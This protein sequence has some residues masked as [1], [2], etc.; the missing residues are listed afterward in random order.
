M[1]TNRAHKRAARAIA[2]SKNIRYPEAIAIA[3][4]DDRVET[5]DASVPVQELD[6]LDLQKFRIVFARR[7]ADFLAAGV[8][9]LT[10]FDMLIEGFESMP[11]QAAA[12]IVDLLPT[13]KREIANGARG[14]EA[15]RAHRD[16][17]GT[18]LVQMLAL[19]AEAGGSPARLRDAADTIEAEM[20]LG[21]S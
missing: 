16:L 6:I 4:D 1:T 10:A 12:R 19:S 3:L 13:A 14:Y 2:A 15:W 21:I 20:R 8:G 11:G 5:S 9:S 18:H 7:Y 17:L